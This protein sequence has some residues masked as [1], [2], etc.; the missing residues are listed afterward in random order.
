MP[1]GNRPI[2]SYRGVGSGKGKHEVAKANLERNQ[3]LLGFANISAPFSGVITKRYGRSRCIHSRRNIRQRRAK[4][5]IRHVNEF[6][7][8]SRAGCGAG[9]GSVARNQGP[10]GAHQ[11]G[12]LPGKTFDG[13]ITRHSYALDEVSKTTLG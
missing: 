1:R 6:Q 9:S 3:T 12:G 8:G 5:S 13:T 4:C 10:S 11:R 2:S 7:H